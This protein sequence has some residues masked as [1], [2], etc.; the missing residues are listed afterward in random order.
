M[1]KGQRCAMH[2]VQAAAAASGAT[3]ARTLIDDVMMRHI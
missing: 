1:G 2:L 3:D